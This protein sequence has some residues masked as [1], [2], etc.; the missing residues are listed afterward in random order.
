MKVILTED[1]LGVGDIGE[2]VSVKAGF[3]R[4]YLVPRGLAMES[5]SKSAGSIAHKMRQVEAKKKRLRVSAQSYG[6][7]ISGTSLEL[8]LKVGTGGRVFGSIGTKDIAEKLCQL[9]FEVDRR[10]VI[11]PEPIKK[12]GTYT[13]KVKLHPEVIADVVLEVKAV[14]VAKESSEE[15]P[16]N[17]RS[18]KK[19]ADALAIEKAKEEELDSVTE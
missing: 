19:A 16:R 13:V 9:G 14:L 6:V 5:G 2:T 7:Q 3:A 8:G 15:E 11:L 10:R 12:L 18:S 1:V 4:N 17:S